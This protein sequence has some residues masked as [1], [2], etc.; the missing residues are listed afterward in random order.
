MTWGNL[1]LLAG[2]FLC[3][4]LPWK[5]RM[6]LF[7]RCREGTSHMKVYDLLRGRRTEGAGR[8]SFLLLLFSQT[9]SAANIQY[10]RCH[11]LKRPVLDSIACHPVMDSPRGAE[12][13]AAGS[14]F[15]P[16]LRDEGRC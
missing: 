13:M 3:I 7:S 4:P 6:L 9:S 12:G 10:A 16:R 5:I 15:P 8:E 14:S 1:D 11:L 2:I